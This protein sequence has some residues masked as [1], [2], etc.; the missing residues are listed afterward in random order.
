[1]G[2]VPSKGCGRCGVG[3]ARNGVHGTSLQGAVGA[4]VRSGHDQTQGARHRA[5]THTGPTSDAQSTALGFG[6]CNRA[7]LV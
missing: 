1:M 7:L 3:L 4:V 2:R 5:M 6:G